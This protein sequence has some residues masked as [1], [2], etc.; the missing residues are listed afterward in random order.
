MKIIK[1]R[2][3][4]VFFL[5]RERAERVLAYNRMLTAQQLNVE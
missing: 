4:F 5:K 2:N 3:S 1:T